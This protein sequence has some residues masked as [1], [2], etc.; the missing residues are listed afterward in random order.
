MHSLLIVVGNG[1][2]E[3]MM[4]PFWQD[5]EV[6]EYCTGEVDESAKQRILRFYAGRGETFNSFDDCYKEHGDDW[7]GGTYRKDSDG[8]WREYRTSNPNMEWDWYEVGGRFAGRLELKEGAELRQPVNFSWGWSAEDKEK[9]LNAVPRRADIARLEDIA[10]LDELTA[11]S[12][13]KDGEWM[14]ISSYFE[15]GLVAPYLEGLPGDTL[16]TVVDYHM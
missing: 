1:D 14:D 12:L 4:E 13:L 11:I 3:E 9:V 7:N 8:V 10:N 16:I 5:L 15:G 6:E 2:L